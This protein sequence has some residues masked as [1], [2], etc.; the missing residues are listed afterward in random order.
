MAKKVISLTER[1][2]KAKPKP[3]PMLREMQ[4][5]PDWRTKPIPKELPEQIRWLIEEALEARAHRE[6]IYIEL[7]CKIKELAGQLERLSY[8]R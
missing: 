6:R 7:L 3:M 1:R 4:P 2:A 5:S 8:Y